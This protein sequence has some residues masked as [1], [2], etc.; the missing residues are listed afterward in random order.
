M[1]NIKINNL[2]ELDLSGNKLFEDSESFM[3]ELTDT[4]LTIN[5]GGSTPACSYF[6]LTVIG[7]A[8]VTMFL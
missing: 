8:H 4:E 7:A 3:T 2:S 6:L 5:K 1:A